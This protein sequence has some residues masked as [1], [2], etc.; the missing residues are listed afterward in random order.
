MKMAFLGSV[1]KF[2]ENVA[3]D[4][5]DTVTGKS[6]YKSYKKAV[7]PVIQ[8]FE[9]FLPDLKEYYESLGSK[10]YITDQDLVLENIEKQYIDYLNQYA[11]YTPTGLIA[12]LVRN[13]LIQA[14]E[15]TQALAS[16]QKQLT[17][18]ERADIM[19]NAVLNWARARGSLGEWKATSDLALTGLL[20][21]GIGAITGYYTG[22]GG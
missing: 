3:G 13:A 15:R 10:F 18:R 16:K 2:F 12:Q 6:A 5:F 22:K 4:V 21:E 19:K 7:K 20:W 11:P 9:E 8:Y 14:S 17:E 1:G